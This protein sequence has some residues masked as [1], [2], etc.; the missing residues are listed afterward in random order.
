MVS[1]RPGSNTN[2]QNENEQTQVEGNAATVLLDGKYRVERVIGEGAFGRVY[3]ATDTRLRRSVA[4]KELLATRNATDPDVFQRYLDRFGREARAGGAITHPNVVTVYEMGIDADQN[5]YLVMEYV[6]GTN[7]RDLLAQV[8]EL[9]VERTVAIGLDVARGLEVVH[10]ADIVHR[11][12][13]PANIMISRRGNAKVGD[14]G[15]AQVGTESQRTQVATGHPGTP[16]YMSPEQASGFGYIDG[17]SDLYSLGLVLYEMIVGEPFARRRTPLAQARPNTPSALVAIVD[18]L[19]QK[20]PDQRF[21]SATD[22]I[23]ELS[24]L[25]SAP[26]PASGT[27]AYVLP[28]PPPGTYPPGPP[29]QQPGGYA[30]PVGGVPSAYGGVSSQPP[31]APGPYTS[32]AQPPSP[33]SGTGPYPYTATGSQAPGIPPATYN[34]GSQQ[35]P[36]APYGTQ[37]LPYAQPPPT[38]PSKRGGLPLPAILGI[39]AAVILVVGGIGIAA[40][41]GGGGKS[42]TATVPVGTQIANAAATSTTAIG[43]IATPN[44]PTFI[45]PTLN[46]PTF[47]LST[48]TG[49][50]PTATARATGTTATATGRTSTPVGATARPTST[51]VAGTSLVGLGT[52]KPSGG[53]AFPTASNQVKLAAGK[54]F[55][56]TVGPNIYVDDANRYTLHYPKEWEQAP[57]DADT[58]VQFTFQGTTISGVTTSD[59]NGEKKPTPQQLADQIS[60]TFSKQL[61]NFKLTETTQVKVAGQDGVRL[62]YTFTDKNNTVT[63]GGYLVTFSTDQT[64]VLFSCYAA[65]DKFTANIPT[66]DSVAGSFTGGLSLD[67][68]Y[69]DSQSRFSF[70]Y[71]KDWTERKSSQP[72]V[73]ALVGPPSGTPSFNVVIEDSKSLTL[74]QY[75]DANFRTI[76][77]PSRGLKS[78][79]KVSESDTTIDAQPAKLQIYTADLAGDGTIYELHQWFLV[80]SGKGYVL[81][82]AVVADKA[83]DYAGY[84]PIIA[85]SF[86]LI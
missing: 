70:D 15:I 57:G 19:M 80:A 38:Q 66:F 23:A 20:D 10:E 17:R 30:N 32:G 35:P 51:A 40:S 56:T 52:S 5:T 2:P 71:P 60:T 27:G 55:P 76:A 48:P 59:L 45:A 34:P 50:A 54:P 81:T 36:G 14:F 7:L 39:L 8:G 63:L 67:K 61:T 41:R 42:A 13:K 46:V 28:P 33:S 64:I 26:Q 77:D 1:E 37:P 83:K 21:Q 47:T 58:D 53:T 85:N 16:L 65:N 44:V 68:T 29:S 82:Y 84:G 86:V 78:Y 24:R 43:G 11:D 73:V 75:Y 4:V 22:L 72:Q 79:K 25:S 74:Q 49:N 62:L 9:P 3:L 31:G 18:R 12:L 69:T 6:D